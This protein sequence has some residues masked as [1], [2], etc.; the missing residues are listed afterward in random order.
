MLRS[1]NINIKSQSALIT[2]VEVKELHPALE[3]DIVKVIEAKDCIKDILDDKSNKFMVITGP[4]SIHDKNSAYEYANRLAKLAEVVG[5]KIMLVMRVYFEKPRTTVGWKGLIYDPELNDSSD[6]AT[7]IKMAREIMLEV[8]RK[9]LPIATEILEPIIPQYID[10]LISWTAIGAR[11]TESQTHRQLTSGLS[12]P[13][14]FKNAT[15]GDI[16]VAV[17][18]IKTASHE[19]SFIG[20]TDGG[21]VGVFNTK[22]NKYGHIVLRGGNKGPNYGSEYIAFTKEV[23]RKS[24]LEANIIVDCSH[25]NSAKN[26]SNQCKVVDSVIEQLNNGEK[27]IKGIM[28]ESHLEAGNQ[29]INSEQLNPNVSITDACIDWD[30]TEALIKKLHQAL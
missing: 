19:H 18:A 23:M 9:G 20:I 28:L 6:I 16:N 15:D 29:N 14:G 30:E 10:D 27:T 13:I 8:T 3:A 11:T 21:C 2:P 4:C 26:H 22:G 5:D 25:A 24:G 12:M 7:G 1:N 17:D